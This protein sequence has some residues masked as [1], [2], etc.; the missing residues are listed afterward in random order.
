MS[1]LLFAWPFFFFQERTKKT[2][3]HLLSYPVL[4]VLVPVSITG[5]LSFT[6]S[7]PRLSEVCPTASNNLTATFTHCFLRILGFCKIDTQTTMQTESPW[8]MKG[9]CKRNTGK[10][11]QSYINNTSIIGDI[12]RQRTAWNP[13]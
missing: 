8:H 5:S 3:N 12:H 11:K 13:V 10:Q 2:V 4:V 7:L 1:Q 9:E 6:P